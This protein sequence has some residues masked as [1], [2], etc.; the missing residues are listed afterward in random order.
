MIELI[1]PD[2]SYYILYK[3]MMDEWHKEG[4]KIAPW[5]L[6]LDYESEE[7]FDELLNHLDDV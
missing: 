2:K 3:E 1:K 4:G 5:V 6:S 7:E